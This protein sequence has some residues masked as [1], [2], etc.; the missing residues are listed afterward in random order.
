MLRYFCN[1]TGR[2]SDTLLSSAPQKKGV[3]GMRRTILL[4]ASM[5]LSV[6][7]ASPALLMASLISP[8]DAAEQGAAPVEGERFT[9]PP[10]T[11][12]VLGDQYSGGKALKIT[13]GQALPTKQITITETSKVL[14]RARAGQTG[15]SPTL[16]IRVDGVNKGTWSISSTNLAHYIYAEATLEPGTYTIGLKGGDLAQGRN[17]FVDV[18]S[19]PSQGPAAPVFPDGIYHLRWNDDSDLSGF[20]GWDI[21]RMAS[22]GSNVVQITNTEESAHSLA[23]SPDGTKLAFMEDTL[24]K[25]MLPD[26]SVSTLTPPN[27]ADRSNL[28]WSP[29]SQTLIY[30]YLL[31]PGTGQYDHSIARYPDEVMIELPGNDLLPEWGSDNRIY[32]RN[33]DRGTLSANPDGSD[34]KLITRHRAEHPPRLSPD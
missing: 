32:W 18:V 33:T 13:S 16:T 2:R 26:G 15:G 11:Q 5:A 22:D 30:D 20:T 21:Y 27:S 19:F 23:M 17:V 25:V 1:V 6:L 9:N 29:D 10:G 31:N 3:W 24:I 4:L 8:A 14:V 28:A 12:V 7:V 34:V